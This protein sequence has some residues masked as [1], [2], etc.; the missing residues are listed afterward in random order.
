MNQKGHQPV[1]LDLNNPVFQR[2]LFK[3]PKT[4]QPLGPEPFGPELTAEG[5]LEAEGRNPGPD[6]ALGLMA[7]FK[8]IE[9]WF[10]L[11]N[12]FFNIFISH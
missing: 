2:Q 4:D 7:S 12:S 8:R 10:I 3:L 9:T 6:R 5:Q 1:L 11:F